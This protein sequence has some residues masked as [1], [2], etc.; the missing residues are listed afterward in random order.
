MTNEEVF[1]IV[2]KWTEPRIRVERKSPVMQSWDETIAR[3]EDSK[4]YAR[5]LWEKSAPPESDV[6]A[7]AFENWKNGRSY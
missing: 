1:A 6:F 2:D 4:R 3:H 7:E 5:E